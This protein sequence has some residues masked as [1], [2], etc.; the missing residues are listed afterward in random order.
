MRDCVG[1]PP[2]FFRRPGRTQQQ[3]S[4]SSRVSGFDPETL[5]LCSPARGTA[6]LVYRN[7]KLAPQTLRLG[8]ASAC[9]KASFY[10]QAD[11]VVA[12]ERNK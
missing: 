1:R 12:A 11:V 8:D 9:A 10:D 6:P 3:L 5:R 4:A 7:C 2:H